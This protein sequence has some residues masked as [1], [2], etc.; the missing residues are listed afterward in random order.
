MPMIKPA[1]SDHKRPGAAPSVLMLAALL[2]AMFMA[3]F[4]FF[5]V[6]VAAPTI[7]AKLRA[8]QPTLQLIVG[9]YAF[10]YAAGLISGGRL[11]DLLG[12][13]RLFIVGMFGFTLASGLCGLAATSAELVAAR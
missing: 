13:R 5:V 1:T 3:Q 10:A 12:H 4:D 2:V 9:G 8:S 6:N 7:E 11:G